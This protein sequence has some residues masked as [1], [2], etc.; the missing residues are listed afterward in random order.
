MKRQPKYIWYYKDYGCWVKVEGDCGKAMN[1]GDSFN[2]RLGKELRVP[3]HLRIDKQQLWYVE[4]GQY[5][6]R[7]NLQINEIYEIED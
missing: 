7:L 2:M 6:V 5:K 4:V 1:S 3:C